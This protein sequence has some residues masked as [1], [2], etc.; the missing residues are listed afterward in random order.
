[1]NA[2]ALTPVAH[3]AIA[4]A[5]EMGVV[6][7]ETCGLV[8]P[9][10]VAWRRNPCSRCGISVRTRR[11]RSLE[12]SLA[13]LVAGIVCYFPANLLPVIHTDGIGG[14]QDSTILSGVVSFW[15]AGA[16]DIAALIFTAS[17][18]VPATKF[19]G[20][21]FL[22]W[23][24]RRGSERARITRGELYR[25]VEFIGYWSML[26]VVVV[27]L[28]CALLQFRTFERADPRMGIFFFC[29]VV[30]TTMFSALSFDPRL[31]WDARD[32]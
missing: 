11:P 15:R 18:A 14:A 30:I 23:S 5:R 27:G 21:G 12:I 32:G 20:L 17:V 25:F 29:A 9:R 13:W 22:L 3:H 28:T 6:R 1:M 7:C 10:E 26:D 8:L 24:V 2:P 4:R 31:I 19:L 16:W